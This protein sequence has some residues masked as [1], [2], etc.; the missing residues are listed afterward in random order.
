MVVI[1]RKTMGLPI[2]AAWT[3][4]KPV[5]VT[6]QMPSAWLAEYFMDWIAAQFVEEILANEGQ[7]LKSVGTEGEFAIT[8]VR[9]QE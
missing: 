7:H 8:F 6:V 4:R 9:E 2:P 3:D 1:R 5:T